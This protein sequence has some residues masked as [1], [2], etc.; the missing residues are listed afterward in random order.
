MLADGHGTVWSLGEREC[1]LQR[2][3]QKV[4][5]ETP[6]PMVDDAL[7]AELSA[8][9]VAAAKAI[10][11]VGAGTVEFLAHGT[12]A[13]SGSWRPTPGC[14]SST[15]SP[16][17]SP[18]WTSSPSSCGSRRGSG[19]PRHRRRR[20]GAAI[21]VR[22][23]AEDPAQGWRPTGGTVRRFAVPGVRTEFDVPDRPGVRL[24]SSV[25]DGTPVGTSYDPMLAK[26]DRLGARPGPRPPPG[27]PPRWPARRCTA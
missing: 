21:E 9:A 25:V 27:W 17:A 18:A 23:Y 4:V 2:R 6:S 22:L 20:A 11:Y 5:E 1:S 8:A 14:R 13:P 3:H 26:V 24:D 16:S 12:T 10:D 15:R 7:R 19:C